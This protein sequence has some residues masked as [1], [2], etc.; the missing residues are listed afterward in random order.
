MLISGIFRI[1]WDIEFPP[2]SMKKGGNKNG[3]CQYFAE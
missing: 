2:N 1:A 3:N